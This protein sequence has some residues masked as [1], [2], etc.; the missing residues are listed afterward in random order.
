MSLKSPGVKLSSLF[1]ER[2]CI[3]V[4]CAVKDTN[5]FDAVFDGSVENKIVADWEAA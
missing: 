1:F 5:E 4:A 3:N 2:I